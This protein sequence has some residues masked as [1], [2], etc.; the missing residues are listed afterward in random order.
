MIDTSPAKNRRCQY[1]KISNWTIGSLLQIE[2]FKSEILKY[3]KISDEEIIKIVYMLKHQFAMAS[4]DNALNNYK[5]S[6]IDCKYSVINHPYK[7][8]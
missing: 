8:V 3:E 1:S 2:E 5:L 4:D 6:I 7:I